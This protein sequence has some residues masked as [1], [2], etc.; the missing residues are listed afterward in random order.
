MVVDEPLDVRDEVTHQVLHSW[1]RPV[2]LRLGFGGDTLGELLHI[3][4]LQEQVSVSLI[5][6][7]LLLVLLAFGKYNSFPVFIILS[8]RYKNDIPHLKQIFATSVDYLLVSLVCW[9]LSS[10]AR[11]G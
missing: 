2:V 3:T 10:E 8:D 5:E 7:Q 1:T 9:L 4:D 6:G 11:A